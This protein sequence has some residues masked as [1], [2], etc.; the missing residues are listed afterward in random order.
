MCIYNEAV[1][2]YSNGDI[3]SHFMYNLYIAIVIRFSY[4]FFLFFFILESLHCMFCKCN[5]RSTINC[6]NAAHI[7]PLVYHI[8]PRDKYVPPIVSQRCASCQLASHRKI[9]SNYISPLIIFS[10]F[11]LILLYYKF[12]IISFFS[13][14]FFFFAIRIFDT[15]RFFEKY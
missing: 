6:Y 9:L 7:L 12:K 1:I 10:I 2:T 4:S 11:Y 5:K 3:T 8:P 14:H 13:E 15:I